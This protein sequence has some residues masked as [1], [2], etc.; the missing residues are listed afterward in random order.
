MAQESNNLLEAFLARGHQL[1]EKW[2]RMPGKYLRYYDDS[3]PVDFLTGIEED[4]KRAIIAHLLENT[5]KWIKGLDESTRSLQVGSFEK[6]VFPVLRAVMANLVAS[7]L[8]AV[9][10]LD[11]PTGVVFYFD[12]LYG[13][14]KGQVRRGTHMYDVRSG[15][16]QDY[17]YTDEI[18]EQERLNTGDGATTTYT[19]NLAWTPVRAGTVRISDGTQNIV[20]NGNGAL[21]GDIGAGTNT[22]DYN[23]GA[24]N[25]TFAAATDTGDAIVVDYEYNSEANDSLPEIDL[26]LTMAPV[27]ART[28]KLRARWSIEAQQDFQAYHGVNAEVELVTFMANEI[29]KEINAKIVRHIRSVA[30]A[31]AGNWDRTP[32]A[33]VPWIWHKETLYDEFI[34]NSNMIFSATQRVGG[35]W[36]VAGVDVCNVVE[37]LSKFTPTPPPKGV[38]GIRKI[39]RIGEFDIYKDPTYP[40]SEWLMG[41]KGS[42]FLDTGYIYAPYL[43]LYTTGTITLDDMIA[44]K[45]MAQRSALKVV[46]SRMY[47]TGTMARTGNL[48][49]P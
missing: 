49:T 45:A 46:N 42:T 1:I 3:R 16:A 11:A 18:V 23:T 30:S 12:V 7:D 34:R 35:N 27:T 44:R 10:P 37:T 5:H 22:I 6:F 41:H 17:H 32:A 24:Y 15:P 40:D 38:A 8:V 28:N 43:A 13:S 2:S 26:Q 25:V 39:G 33:G 36:I 31:G 4:E 9:H 21:V 48:Y 19:G 47:A 20:D 14:D 29:M